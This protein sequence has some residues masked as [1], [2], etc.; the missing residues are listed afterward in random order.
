M[1]NADISDAPNECR[2]I[3]FTVYPAI[4]VRSGRVVPLRQGDYARETR[5][6]EEPLALA[7]RHAAEG[8]SWLHLVDLDAARVGSRE[9]QPMCGT[10]VPQAG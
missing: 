3:S 9:F 1:L 10:R 8:A 5:Y 7:R 2:G 6:D 4:D